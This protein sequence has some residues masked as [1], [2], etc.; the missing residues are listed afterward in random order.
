MDRS[1]N[2]GDV[3]GDFRIS[4]RSQAA[5]PLR[6]DRD[7]ILVG[8]GTSPT[9]IASATLFAEI[10]MEYWQ[11]GKRRGRPWRRF[12][13]AGRVPGREKSLNGTQNRGCLPVN[14]LSVRVRDIITR[15]GVLGG[16]V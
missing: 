16:P 10:A 2:R 12:W 3:S 15:P 6:G 13:R 11:S 7:G 9:S 8:S 14:Q 1:K 4:R 5:I